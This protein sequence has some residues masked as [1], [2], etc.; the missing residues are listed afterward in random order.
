VRSAVAPFGCCAATR[1]RRSAAASPSAPDAH[2]VVE[3]DDAAPPHAR[4]AVE[5]TDR[6]ERQILDV[7]RHAAARV[8][9]QADVE[10]GVLVGRLVGAAHH[11]LDR[12]RVVAVGDRE[13]GRLQ[14]V[15]RRAVLVLHGDRDVDEPDA[16]LEA[17]RRGW[18]RKRAARDAGQCQ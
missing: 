17:R 18:F 1:S 10:G 3:R 11:Q 14:V 5:E 7:A 4:N 6:G 12:A 13:V 8:H 16:S 9:Q 2:V 15:D